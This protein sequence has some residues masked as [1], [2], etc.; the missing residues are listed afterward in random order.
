MN[1]IE[2]LKAGQAVFSWS[3]LY[4]ESNGYKLKMA[5]TRDAIMFPVTTMKSGG[6]TPVTQMVRR[7]VNALETQQAADFLFC[8]MMTPKLEDL[9]YQQATVHLEPITQIDGDICAVST[10]IRHSELVDNALAKAGDAGGLICTVGKS[11]VLS[12]YLAD[13]KPLKYG[14]STA[15]N[16]GWL[17]KTAGHLA[18]TPGLHAWQP[19]GYQH[20]DLHADPSQTLRLVYGAAELTYPDGTTEVV[21]LLDVATNSKLAG[22]I[23]HEGPLRYLRQVG[24]SAP[25]D[26]FGKSIMGEEGLVML[27]VG[28]YGTPDFIGMS[29]P[30]VV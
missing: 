20:N 17:G 13:P 7:M 10:D 28:L 21:R 27:P 15:C 3:P 8:L 5:V 6:T 18:V 4:N 24:V 16:Y 25:Q 2:Q 23:S 30:Q 26:P 19:P 12:N 29:S 22:L 9:I 1:V 14:A 11:W